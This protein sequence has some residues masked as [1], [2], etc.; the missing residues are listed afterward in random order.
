MTL[1]ATSTF[2]FFGLS[3]A[4]DFVSL[5]RRLIPPGWLSPTTPPQI[6]FNTTT[7][8]FQHN[9]QLIHAARQQEIAKRSAA[10]K[11]GYQTRQARLKAA[12]AAVS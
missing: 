1:P 11:K 2:R 7:E 8:I 10:A 4:T 9:T 12:Q 3:L 6:E 5:S